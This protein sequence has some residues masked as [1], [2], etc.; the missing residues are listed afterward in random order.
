MQQP[1]RLR[2]RLA[3]HL[4]ARLALDPLPESHQEPAFLVAGRVKPDC[5]TRRASAGGVEL[6]GQC[7]LPAESGIGIWSRRD[8]GYDR[9]RTKPYD[10]VL[11]LLQEQRRRYDEPLG[12]RRLDG[13]ANPWI[14]GVSV[15]EQSACAAT[16]PTVRLRRYRTRTPLHLRRRRPYPRLRR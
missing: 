2:E 9:L 16:R 14:H 10:R 6:Y 7:M 5:G 12:L 8:F 4:G 11:R 3:L 13:C 1:Q 15:P